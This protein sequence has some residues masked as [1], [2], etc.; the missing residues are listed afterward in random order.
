[1]RDVSKTYRTDGAAVVALQGFSMSIGPGEFVAVRGSSGSGKT[2]ALLAA[3]GLLS[4]D[5]GEILVDGT[6]VGPLGP[7]GRASLRASR[8]GF[9]FQQFHLIPYLSVLENVLVPLMAAGRMEGAERARQLLERFGLAGRLSHLPGQLSAGEQQRVGMARA[10]VNNP[11]L[12]LA[13]EPTGNLDESN[14]AAVL[15]YIREFAAAGGGVMLVT[16]DA[17]AAGRADRQVRIERGSVAP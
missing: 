7:A 1:M 2:T 15:D 13:D 4:V 12:L 3:A 14:A 6:A 16:H 5:K 11:R 10:L 8:I 17:A 9:A